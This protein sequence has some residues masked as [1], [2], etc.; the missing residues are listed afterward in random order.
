MEQKNFFEKFW[1]LFV[2]IA[3]VLIGTLTFL[4]FNNQKALKNAQQAQQTPTVE[5]VETASPTPTV[6]TD[7]TTANLET[8]S[9][10][11]EVAD[12]EADINNT[13]LTDI[14]KELADIETELST[15]E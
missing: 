11:D 15:P 13:D 6:I 10:S 9:D 5:E 4:W 1:Y 3:L 8:Q 7:Q 14:D 12:I 2:I